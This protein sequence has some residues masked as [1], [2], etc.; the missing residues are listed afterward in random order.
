MMDI[1]PV[2]LEADA[3]LL[4]TPVYLARLSG[5]MASFLDRLRCCVHGNL[6]KNRLEDKVGGALSVAWLRH[7]GL[8]TSLLSLI[9][10]FM[11]LQMI[12]VGSGISCAFG[13]P[14][15]S[16]REGTGQFDPNQKLG[17]LEDEFGIKT[18]ESLVER[19]ARVAKKING[20][21]E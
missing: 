11:S 9:Y 13:A 14:A 17:I 21:K 12:P 5:Y 18:M 8:E 16:S 20:I 6:Y 4:A 1:F 15:L 19:V 2:L 10:A 3:L 7:A